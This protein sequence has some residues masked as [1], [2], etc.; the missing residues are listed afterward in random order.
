MERLGRECE[1]P[2]R[3]VVPDDDDDDDDDEDDVNNYSRDMT[4]MT[5]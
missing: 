1:T 3:V 5:T 4:M 2:Q